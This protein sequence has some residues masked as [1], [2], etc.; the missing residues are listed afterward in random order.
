MGQN[1]KQEL[2]YARC[3]MSIQVELLTEIKVSQKSY[4]VFLFILIYLIFLRTG[5]KIIVKTKRASVFQ[6]AA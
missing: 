2:S 6:L 4:L 3:M 1:A 5:R